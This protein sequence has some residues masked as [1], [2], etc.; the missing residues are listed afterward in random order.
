ML[1]D[2]IPHDDPNNFIE[3]ASVD[4]YQGREKELII[5]SAVRCNDRGNVGFLADWRRLNVMLT[6][7]RRGLVVFGNAETLKCDDT[8]SK[9]LEWC[10]KL[11][12]IGCAPKAA[13]GLEHFCM[14]KDGGP[15]MS[16]FDE[17]DDDY[18]EMIEQE[19][20]ISPFVASG[21]VG[22]PPSWNTS[23]FDTINVAATSPFS[24]SASSC[25]GTFSS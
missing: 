24:V 9:W 11:G 14:R 18:E 2:S 16:P 21:A 19:T 6:R 7:A 22:V 3:T 10:G 20:A 12:G 1:R 25:S 23:T 8:W 17:W 5:F 13:A 4:N 15:N